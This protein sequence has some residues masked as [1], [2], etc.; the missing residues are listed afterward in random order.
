[1]RCVETTPHTTGDATV[2]RAHADEDGEVDADAD[3]RLD[4][5]HEAEDG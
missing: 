4:A 2:T 3:E 1:M 5:E